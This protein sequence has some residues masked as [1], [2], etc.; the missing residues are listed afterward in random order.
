M[1][2]ARPMKG[3]SP[4]LPRS[5]SG[6]VATWLF[7]CLSICP[8][9][10]CCRA[11]FRPGSGPAGHGPS[12]TQGSTYFC[13]HSLP[14]SPSGPSL[15]IPASSYT[16]EHCGEVLIEVKELGSVGEGGLFLSL[17][18]YKMETIVHVKRLCGLRER[19]LIN[20]CIHKC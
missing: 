20:H 10:A 16:N 3:N 4:H 14:L 17:F 9:H 15:L 2:H 7:P 19:R 8:A 6:Q 18:H 5:S 1:R 11:A 13:R 12:C